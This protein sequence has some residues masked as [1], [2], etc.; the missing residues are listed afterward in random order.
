MKTGSIT[1]TLSPTLEEAE[2]LA[3]SY[4][5]HH[6][7]RTWYSL[8]KHELPRILS[9][10]VIYPLKQL[11]IWLI[12]MCVGSVV[13]HLT[14]SG[15]SRDHI[16]WQ[17]GLALTLALLHLPLHM[18]FTCLFAQVR[19]GLAERLRFAVICHLQRLSL[20]VHARN[21]SGRIHSKILRDVDQFVNLLRL[22]YGPILGTFTGLFISVGAAWMLDPK[23][24]AFF[25]FMAPAS[26]LL[27]AL[28]RRRMREATRSFRHESEALGAEVSTMLDMM[29]LTRAHGLE[30]RV[31]S[32]L[33]GQLQRIRERGW[34]VDLISQ[35]FAGAS[36]TFFQLMQLLFLGVGSWMVFQE[37]LSIG[38]LV[39]L[40]TYFGLVVEHSGRL[41]N[42]YPQIVQGIEAIHS[43]GE[44]L[45]EEDVENLEGGLQAPA[46]AG[47]VE[48]KQLSYRYPTGNR[49]VLQDLSLH[50]PSG[51][52]VAF[53]GPSG[54]GKSTLMGCILGLTQPSS[55]SVHIDG[56]DLRDLN[57]PSLRRQW[58]YVPQEVVLFNGSL[59][60]NIS[61]GLETVED[62]WL[63]TCIRS[64]HLQ[65]VVERLPEGLDTAIGERG[66]QLSGGER[67]RI[68]ICRAMLRKPRMIILDEATAA[69]DTETEAEVQAAVDQL[70]SGR[71]TLIV[72]HRFAAIRRAHRIFVLDQGELVEQGSQAELLKQNGLFRRLYE[73]QR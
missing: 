63:Q 10:L 30:E 36:W 6:P 72:A 43:I 41:L 58:A 56:L 64:T 52:C 44:I 4:G 38:N 31:R 5:S 42:A 34:R 28:F 1:Q 54:A 25:L 3:K 57:G 33:G 2:Q 48:L 46:L 50:I 29:P 8:C 16:L 67:Q 11:P 68:A 21:A 23:I 37:I 18:L 24:A 12:P 70:I 45:E 51:E 61:Y 49:D 66:A 22:I 20:D 35:S 59:R 32:R 39:M 19:H 14:Q 15:G 27:V 17:L 26:G 40:S 55:G 13:D 73:R 71:T 9:A 60:E 47:E 7:F 53:V 69:M 62:E 65:Q